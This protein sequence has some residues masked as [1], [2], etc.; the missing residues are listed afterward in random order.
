LNTSSTRPKKI[1][2]AYVHQLEPWLGIHERLIIKQLGFVRYARAKQLE[3][4]F[5]QLEGSGVATERRCQRSLRR[6]V[7]LGVL[8]RLDDRPIGLRGSHGSKS[9][10]YALD[11][12]GQ[13]LVG[14]G[15]PAGGKR[16]RRPWMP[17]DEHLT[18]A[19]DVTE[20]YV[21]LVELERVTGALEVLEFVAETAC[22]RSYSSPYG[23]RRWLKPDAYARVRLGPCVDRWFIEVYRWDQ[24]GLNL[25]AK[26]DSYRHYWQSGRWEASGGVCPGVLLLATHKARSATLA[27]AVASQPEPA[28]MLFQVGPYSEAGAI[29]STAPEP[30]A[31]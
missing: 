15:G 10:V 25:A 20:L 11:V 28:Q 18:H 29:L 21:R 3:R 24:S 16:F 9:F 4:L 26:L 12:A 14:A 31:A 17:R 22:W 1:T 27:A 2:E 23:G 5:F 19:L 8:C 30:L 7:D 6:L 13:R